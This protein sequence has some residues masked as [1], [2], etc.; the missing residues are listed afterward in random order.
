MRE[1]AWIKAH[2]MPGVLTNVVTAVAVTEVS[3]YDAPELPSLVAA[4]DRRFFLAEVSSVKAYLTHKNLAAIEA[5]G[6]APFIPFKSNSRSDGPPAWKR[7]WGLF[8]YRHPEF[9]AH[10]HQRSNVESTFSMIKRKFGGAVRSKCHTAQVN[11]VLCKVLCHNLAVLVHA[12]YEL[13]VEPTFTAG[14]AS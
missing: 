8:V 1:H 2:V 14:A 9:L 10:Y 5:V 11:E 6:A 3:T 13:G 4:T 7:L 12:M